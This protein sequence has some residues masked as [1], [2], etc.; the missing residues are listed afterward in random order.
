LSR[1]F[2][3]ISGE[4]KGR[5]LRGPQGTQARPATGLI[6]G[7]IFS[8]LEALGADLSRVLDLYAGTGSLGIEALSRGAQ[9]VLFVEQSA[10]GCL[11]IQE[12][13][14]RTGFK[15]RGQVRQMSVRHALRALL[16][17]A[18]S[19]GPYSLVL[20]DPPFADPDVPR[21]LNDLA[22]LPLVGP[23]STIV[24]RHF[25]R[26]ALENDVGRFT[27]VRERRHGDSVIA[28]YRWRGAEA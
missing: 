9:K 8:M 28:I 21:V 10:R 4:A 27:R 18:N 23:D 14:E 3:V 26:L 16:R 24:V 17:E 22:A 25:R 1:S 6:R 7:A 12:N 2:Q 13:L 5:R 11:V 20:M 19:E 15:G